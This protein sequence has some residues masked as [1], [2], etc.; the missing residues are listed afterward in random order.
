MGGSVA[1]L[2]A[3]QFQAPGYGFGIAISGGR[4]NPHFTTGEPSIV[5]SDVLRVGPAWGFLQ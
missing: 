2:S 3:L 4:D 1:L 5:V